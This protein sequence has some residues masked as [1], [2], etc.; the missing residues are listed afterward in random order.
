MDNP[1]ISV[2]IPVYNVERYISKCIESITSQTYGNLEIL[3]VDDGSTDC[4]GAICD[5][6]AMSDKRIRVFHNPN[7]GVSSAR[8]FGLI[9]A[10]GDFISF[11]DSDDWLDTNAYK[12]LITFL[13]KSDS[14]IV[15]FDFKLVS[16]GNEIPY[17]LPY[18]DDKDTFIRQYLDYYLTSVWLCLINRDFIIRNN[19]T[20]N[21]RVI[22]SEDLLFM[23]EV[24]IKA[25]K[26]GYLGKFFYYH[27]RDN[28]GSITHSFDIKKYNSL[29]QLMYNM[30]RILVSNGI[31]EKY[32]QEYHWRVLQCKT[33]MIISKD[34]YK[35]FNDY[36]PES[37]RYIWSSPYLNKKIKVMM[38]LMSVHLDFATRFI[39][40]LR[41][42][43]NR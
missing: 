1:L 27:N 8:N 5:E 41:R 23:T 16:N 36:S 32:C 10:K 21:E 24:I 11:V 4:S 26:L 19:I 35:L 3:L 13:S 20:F 18:S 40:E 29:C 2:I 25:H 9:H 33:E 43:F 6:Y 42:V 28:I 22:I 14:E 12:E 15:F 31:F 39:I 34:Y 17:T 7:K 30:K 38:W 37:N